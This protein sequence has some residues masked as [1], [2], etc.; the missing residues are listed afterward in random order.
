MS[1]GAVL[2][3]SAPLAAAPAHK[4]HP[5]A[6]A[7]TAK[8]AAPVVHSGSTYRAPSPDYGAPA[9]GSISRPVGQVTLSIGRGELINLP[10]TM[11][12]VF[13]A[14]DK[15]ADLQVKSNHQLY[16]YGRTSGE[17]T[18][19]ASNAEGRVVWSANVRVGSNIDSVG[20]MLKLA[21]PEAHILVS[22]ISPTS[23]MLTGTVAAPE[24]AA[25]AQRLTQTYMGKDATVITRL[26]TATPLQVNLHVR[27]AEVSRTLSRTLGT[28]LTG[29]STGTGSVVF[30]VSR[31]SNQGTI[32]NPS[33]YVQSGLANGTYTPAPTIYNMASNLA[34]STAIGIGGKLL[35]VDLLGSLDLGESIGLV[36]TLAEPNLTAVSGETSDFLAGGE[37][38][39]PMSSGLGTVSVDYKT[40]GVSLAFTPT[41]L[42]DG[43]ISLRVRPEVSELTSAGAVSINGYTIPALTVRRAETTVELGSG[44]SMMIAGLLSNNASHTISKLP[45][46]G[47]LPVLGSLFK[48]T[49]FQRGESELVIV[50]TP[51]LVKPVNASDI[52]LPTDGLQ[53]PTTT[54]EVL[55][56]ML[57]D[58]KSGA[59]TVGPRAANGAPPPRVGLTDPAPAAPAA[60]EPA[61]PAATAATAPSSA[62]KPVKNDAPGFSLN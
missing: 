50:V 15:I 49:E 12:D 5:R 8:A 9:T 13:I 55:G 39:I 58:G 60:A 26:R 52:H 40:Y 18:V 34:N 32:T 20:Q 21:M 1:A 62:A 51:Y 45:G 4:P 14:D 6:R 53:N 54:Q 37:Y 24:D 31:G 17:T 2:G 16:L 57:T 27:I 41:V 10:G 30:G 56:N 46:V 33:G 44:Q 47:D 59:P 38:P 23:V 3:L 48:S 7:A 42:A 22:T 43:R 28:N 11:K 35:G 36:T 19:Y 25:E 61:A 29:T